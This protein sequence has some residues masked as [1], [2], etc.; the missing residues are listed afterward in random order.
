MKIQFGP[1]KRSLSGCFQP[2]RCCNFYQVMTGYLMMSFCLPVV[3]VSIS[4]YSNDDV[5]LNLQSQ[6]EQRVLRI[7]SKVGN[8]FIYVFQVIKV[9]VFPTLSN[10]LGMI[11]G[12]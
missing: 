3:A 4:V 2:S 10:V 9:F 7:S 12:A 5:L 11:L 1:C 6:T 8:A